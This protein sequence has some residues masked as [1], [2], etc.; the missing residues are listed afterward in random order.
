VFYPQQLFAFDSHPF[1]KRYLESGS[2]TMEIFQKENAKGFLALSSL[3]KQ[4]RL[5]QTNFSL[6]MRL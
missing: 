1:L 4:T 2:I 3:E 5:K 6:S